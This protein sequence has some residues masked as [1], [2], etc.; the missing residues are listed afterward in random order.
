M[1]DN[2]ELYGIDEFMIDESTTDSTSVYAWV[3]TFAVLY[4]IQLEW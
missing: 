1:N 4:V 2:N 3:D